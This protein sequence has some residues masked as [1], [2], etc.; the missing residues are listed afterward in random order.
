MITLK[1]L[2]RDDALAISNITGTP[3]VWGVTIGASTYRTYRVDV[4]NEREISRRAIG[5]QM[6]GAVLVRYKVG[7]YIVEDRISWPD[8]FDYARIVSVEGDNEQDEVRKVGAGH[9]DGAG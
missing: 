5:T 6:S 2:N 8:N 1:F 7:K 4:F 3:V 9:E